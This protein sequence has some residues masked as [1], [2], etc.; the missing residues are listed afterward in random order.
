MSE[1]EASTVKVLLEKLA[2]PARPT[3]PMSC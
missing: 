2:M 3:A 1:P